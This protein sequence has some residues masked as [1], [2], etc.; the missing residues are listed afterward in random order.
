MNLSQHKIVLGSLVITESAWIFGLIGVV[1]LTI[2]LEGSPIDWPIV[3]LIM[4][5]SVI[6]I[7]AQLFE[8]MRPI[9]VGVL[10]TISLAVILYL[11]IAFSISDSDTIID[12]NW[13]LDIFSSAPPD[14]YVAHIVLSLIAGLILW[15]RGAKL[16]SIISPVDTLS[17]SFRIGI[18][19]LAF[20]SIID[21]LHSYDMGVFVVLFIF[22]ASGLVGLSAGYL[23]PES[24]NS[25]ENNTFLKV[26]AVIVSVVLSIGVMISVIHKI[27]TSFLSGQ[28]DSAGS[29]IEWLLFIVISP[30]VFV[31]ELFNKGLMQFFSRDFDP[32][33]AGLE[34][35]TS[36]NERPEQSTSSGTQSS[37]QPSNDEVS[38]QTG[39]DWGDVVGVLTIAFIAI[40]VLVIIFLLAMVIKRGMGAL[41]DNYEGD[42]ESLKGDSN[43]VV[44]LAKL[45]AGLLPN[46]GFG[47]KG[48]DKL[49]LPDGPPGV[50]EAIKL[51]YE[52]LSVGEKNGFSRPIGKTAHE[53]QG[54]LE[55][56]IPRNLVSSVT[57]AFS[58]AL[59]GRIPSPDSELDQMRLDM[60]PVKGSSNLLKK[61]P[62]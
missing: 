29:V 24:S 48:S 23:M 10:R 43:A 34:E 13:I 39:I 33:A 31:F 25:S 49:N 57:N 41:T 61:P 53:F 27:I 26:I 21:I 45:L 54:V 6:F 19:A 5:G 32:V 7:Q 18:V 2:G 22:F 62:A 9:F 46:F 17:K 11:G 16:S 44:D 37:Y 59:Y 38:I 28:F 47:R 51:Y 52:L 55:Q 36:F 56:I 4:A 12:L 40:L 15:L 8:K 42:A 20:A 35:S 50:V 30:L 60:K 14:K 58:Q 1:G 3:A